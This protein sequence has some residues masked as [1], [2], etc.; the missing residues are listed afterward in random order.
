MATR[1]RTYAKP[2]PPSTHAAAKASRRRP[3][4]EV[5][6]YEPNNTPNGGKAAEHHNIAA[7]DAKDR[8]KGKSKG[9]GRR[10]SRSSRHN[11]DEDGD[12]D[13][14]HDD[15]YA[16][17]DKSDDE[18]DRDDDDDYRDQ[19]D[20]SL[21]SHPDD[22]DD[23]DDG[24]E[25][26]SSWSRNSP[27]SSSGRRPR[28]GDRNRWRG[29]PPP[30][31][32]K[33]DH[34][35]EDIGK[36]PKI[37]QT[38]LIDVEAWR[39]RAKHY[40]P[41]A[42]LA[43]DLRDVIRGDGR[44]LIE[45]LPLAS[46]YSE[47]G[48]EL[49]MKTLAV[50]DRKKIVNA[51]ELMHRYGTIKR[52]VGEVIGKFNGRFLSIEADMRS[53]KLPVYDDEHRAYKYLKALALPAPVEQNVM[54]NAGSY[55]YE[56]FNDA[57]GLLYPSTAPPHRDAD[58]R[59]GDSKG[60]GDSRG[61]SGK[62]HHQRRAA[63]VHAIEDVE[64]TGAA[65]EQY[66]DEVND[67]EDDQ[68]ASVNNVDGQEG[69]YD[70]EYDEEDEPIAEAS[71]LVTDALESAVT[72]M[73]EVLTITAD[74]L[75]ALTQSRGF[76]QLSKGKGKGKKKGK[77]DAGKSSGGFQKTGD[78]NGQPSKG[79]A[80]RKG[81]E[82][83][84]KSGSNQSGF[85]PRQRPAQVTI[86]EDASYVCTTGSPHIQDASQSMS[87]PLATSFFK[88]KSPSKDQ[89][90][91]SWMTSGN[92]SAS[93]SFSV[94]MNTI[95]SL[96]CIPSEAFDIMYISD[97]DGHGYMV[98]DTACA[99]TCHGRER[100]IRPEQTLSKHDITILGVEARDPFR[101][102]IAGCYSTRR[103]IM[104][105]SISKIMMLI[106]ASSLGLL[107][108]LGSI[109]DAPNK[110]AHF[111]A[112]GVSNVPLKMTPNGFLAVCIIDWPES[113]I[114]E[115]LDEW[116][117]IGRISDDVVLPP[118]DRCPQVSMD[119]V[120]SPFEQTA[121]QSFDMASTD[122]DNEYVCSN[123][124]VADESDWESVEHY[125]TADEGT[126]KVSCVMAQPDGE[127]LC[128]NR[129]GDSHPR[130][131][132][133]LLSGSLTGGAQTATRAEYAV[134]QNGQQLAAE[135]ANVRASDARPAATQQVFE[136]DAAAL[137]SCCRSPMPR[138][139][140]GM[141]MQCEYSQCGDW[142]CSVVCSR[143]H[144]CRP[145]SDVAA[146][147]SDGAATDG[148]G[149]ESD[150]SHHGFVRGI[151]FLAVLA[152]GAEAPTPSK[153][154]RASDDGPP[155]PPPKKP[156]SGD[157]PASSPK[158]QR[159]C[160]CHC[161][162]T[163]NVRVVDEAEA[164][165]WWQ[166]TCMHCGPHQ[167]QQLMF[168]P[169][170]VISG[171]LCNDCRRYANRPQVVA[172]LDD[173]SAN[174]PR[175]VDGQR[176]RRKCTNL[177]IWN[178]TADYAKNRD[179]I[180]EA[181]EGDRGML[182]LMAWTMKYQLKHGRLFPF[183]N[184][185]GSGTWLESLIQEIR[186]MPGVL[187]A[188][189]DMC[190]FDFVSDTTGMPILKKLRWMSNSAL[191]L[192]SVTPKCPGTHKHH[193][194]Q[195]KDTQPS[196]SYTPQLGHSLLSSIRHEAWLREP[197]R[198]VLTDRHTKFAQALAVADDTWSPPFD[199]FDVCYLDAN[200]HVEDWRP[201][202]EE[203][204]RIIAPRAAPA[205]EPEA[206]HPLLDA[207][208]ALVPWD[209]QRIQVVKTPKSR[210]IPV[211]IPV[212]H[213]GAALMYNDDSIFVESEPMSGVAF[214]RVKF[215]KPVKVA[216]FF[217]GTAPDDSVAPPPPPAPPVEH[218]PPQ[219]RLYGNG[220]I[221]FPGLSFS[222]L[223]D[224]IR[225][226]V[227]RMHQ[228]F[229]HPPP[230]EFL[231]Q[232]A[233]VGASHTTMTAISALRC[234][235]CIRESKP[236]GPRPTSM[237]KT[238]CGQF[239]DKVLRDIVFVSDIHNIVHM[240]VGLIDDATW[241]F[242]HQRI[243]TRVAADTWKTLCTLW[244]KP[245]GI[246]FSMV[247]DEDGAFKGEVLE[248]L[249]MLGT[250]I[251]FCA[252]GAHHQIAKIETI[253]DYWR[254]CL[255]KVIDSRAIFEPDDLD[256]AI[257][258][259]DHAFNSS[260][261][262]C[263]RTPYAAVFG[264]VPRW[265]GELL[266]DETSAMQR[267]NLSAH[268]ALQF[269]EEHRL[270]A[271]RAFADRKVVTAFK[272]SMM[273]KTVKAKDKDFCV[274][275]ARVGYWRDVGVRRGNGKRSK[276]E[277]YMIG[278]FVRWDERGENAIIAHGHRD[279]RVRRGQVR[280]AV[281][282]ENW[283]P[284]EVDLADLRAAEER[285]RQGI[286]PADMRQDGPHDDEP[287]EPDYDED[288]HRGS[289]EE[290]A[291]SAEDLFMT[292]REDE[293]PG[294]QLFQP[295][296][297]IPLD[298][299]L[300]AAAATPAEAAS[301]AAPAAAAE[302]IVIPDEPMQLEAPARSSN[303][304]AP[305]LR[306]PADLPIA[307][308]ISD[309]PPRRK[310]PDFFQD[311]IEP[312]AKYA[313]GEDFDEMSVL[314]AGF[315]YDICLHEPD[316]WDGRLDPPETVQPRYECLA[317][318]V[319][320]DDTATRQ[321]VFEAYCRDM[322]T[323][324]PEA[325][326]C[327]TTTAIDQEPNLSRKDRK[328]L[329]RELPWREIVKRGKQEI[330]LYVGAAS[331]EAA[332]FNKWQVLRPCSRKECRDK[333]CGLGPVVI[334]KCRI[335]LIGCGHPDFRKLDR[336]APTPTDAAFT[337]VVQIYTTNQ[338]MDPDGAWEMISGDVSNAFLQGEAKQREL[339]IYTAPPRDPILA[340]AGVLVDAELYEVTG[341]IYGLPEAPQIFSGVVTEKMVMLEYRI[342]SLDVICLMLYDNGK[343]IAVVIFHVDDML[344]A[345]SPKYDW[346][347]LFETFTWGNGWQRLS[348]G[349]ITW[350]GRQI[351]RL[352]DGRVRVHQSEK[353][354]ALP[355]RR[356]PP[357][358]RDDHTLVGPEISEYKSNTGSLRYHSGKTRADVAA[359]TSLLQKSSPTL[360][361]PREIY[362]VVE[363]LA[364]TSEVGIVFVAVSLDTGIYVGFGDSSW[365]NAEDL[366]SQTGTLPV[367]VDRRALSGTSV[368]S[369][370]DY[371]TV[372]TRRV[373][374]ST[375]SAEANACDNTVDRMSYYNLFLT[376]ILTGKPSK[377]R[378]P[379]FEQFAV[380]DCKSLYD[381]VHQATPSLEEKR[382]IDIVGIRDA[383]QKNHLPWLPTAQMLADRLTKLS[384][385]PV[386]RMSALME[387]TE[388]TSK[389]AEA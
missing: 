367:F 108:S 130:H 365:A 276:K 46:V 336:Y 339:P 194:V 378:A 265:P 92:R 169:V 311:A 316:G 308:E 193:P 12:D 305:S 69:E 191:L 372:R 184:P 207:I 334:A 346:R 119:I 359:P 195:G 295:L 344:G 176:R 141:G 294:V 21:P 135:A 131:A 19:V 132:L 293:E 314:T 25:D 85:Q 144:A 351:L 277:G 11:D 234:E 383:L 41:L 171:G 215:Q 389:D 273:R 374:R 188:L 151:G 228:N 137:C 23:D 72:G 22:D 126:T 266:S 3:Q 162:R 18:D 275:G 282:W 68:S 205:W 181:R 220:E 177:C 175:A 252:P 186:D 306:R 258:A 81:T 76:G 62:N 326:E 142:F 371:K 312:P 240:V 48:I 117:R 115:D 136:N 239:G 355:I 16:D 93:N 222:Q 200:R 388:V 254:T 360:E 244:L 52:L 287:A 259:T 29:G 166:C 284:D 202:I 163:D 233:A 217:Y 315:G 271:L 221:S 192:M 331:K 161:M 361:D 129:R 190:Q 387:S 256:S 74:K 121:V 98:L 318:V 303:E 168:P 343:L 164:A 386:R 283:T 173:S 253:N 278:T 174:R 279:V 37:Y 224:D 333:N 296:P 185:P 6:Q 187:S 237:P 379:F 342:H 307:L 335:V 45:D 325:W 82:T 134:P 114:P 357:I 189:G 110:V 332:A 368:G 247:F 165:G 292:D 127:H 40:R 154:K 356:V 96:P 289:G 47:L 281:G 291:L 243:T 302:A 94:N 211:D 56:K 83:P 75:K 272:Q 328:A 263:G 84:G 53:A 319:E 267:H 152:N 95:E 208:Q 159:P 309:A 61:K 210:R 376:E 138:H 105:A 327:Y 158:R 380:T 199:T 91:T 382:C 322:P 5:R 4:H 214:P 385:D 313:R 238:I 251:H 337:M 106:L 381:A 145:R 63:E 39:L 8:S 229:G 128:S 341:N 13:G 170:W 235:T 104:P 66:V 124:R 354:K 241:L 270:D 320:S 209:L 125:E 179:K 268:D 227:A 33:W 123:Q 358:T 1:T 369:L 15:D 323:E 246:P 89:D 274:P 226:V 288:L 364:N 257:M 370:H 150:T 201:V 249:S 34:T 216:I 269:G 51:G 286:D 349:D 363:Y 26:A 147:A 90:I 59:K 304:S 362:K 197:K 290:D 44:A 350:N 100:R 10:S 102:G 206:G 329:D 101:F 298:A 38:W 353:V 155:K 54:V 261:K 116:H 348:E 107:S 260:A 7:D 78:Y 352:K 330:Q 133:P 103:N 317:L 255:E 321:D 223:P 310:S 384:W 300:E 50:F 20:E 2:T 338:T 86:V 80:D 24:N 203:A 99:K 182:K 42:E 31:P 264:R 373:V 67:A 299:V 49:L 167:C 204:W 32:P 70:A 43:L 118:S 250:V 122:H 160:P 236:E 97:N 9:R 65:D 55:N 146:S 225:R 14:R 156:R 212:V 73:N 88:S 148:G 218:P 366:K 120:T 30:L 324:N 213:R 77:N 178:R 79:Y 231:R 17:R 285:L 35:W 232:A 140:C 58:R 230:K 57:L 149:S 71:V 172:V 64:D 180:E 262:R 377:D 28:R 301:A 157:V 87:Q 340:A 112:I 347:P 280:E 111:R 36:T 153:G 143:R 345:I 113:G 139:P 248:N 242:Q 245:P 109:L 60:K 183:E 297:G 27:N 196:Q 198:F 219:G 375:L